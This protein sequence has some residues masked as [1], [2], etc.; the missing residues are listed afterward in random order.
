MGQP[1]AT[2]KGF[3]KQ[4]NVYRR[5]QCIIHNVRKKMGFLLSPIPN[6]ASLKYASRGH[7]LF[8]HHFTSS[9]QVAPWT[10]HPI[11]KRSSDSASLVRLLK[12]LIKLSVFCHQTAACG[13]LWIA[14]GILGLL[15]VPH[16]VV[17]RKIFLGFRFLTFSAERSR[18]HTPPH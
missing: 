5:R 1:F 7:Q 17:C 6:P 12:Q 18:T 4:N 10:H 16:K 2:Q 9:G 15:R 14:P 8:S 13:I 3:K 11:S